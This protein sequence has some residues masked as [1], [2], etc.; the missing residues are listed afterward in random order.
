MA[1]LLPDAS[2]ISM[3]LAMGSERPARTMTSY[4]ASRAAESE[5][6]AWITGLMSSMESPN[7][8]CAMRG[9]WQAIQL[10][11]P[12]SVLISPLWARTRKGWA[13][14]QVGKVLVE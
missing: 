3:A 12:L 10:I 4:T 2:G 11:L 1:G 9:S 5:L 7:V 14:C 6:S 13:R 8:S